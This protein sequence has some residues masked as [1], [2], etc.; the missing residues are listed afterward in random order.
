LSR[1]G[2]SYVSIISEWKKIVGLID[3]R[4][5]RLVFVLIFVYGLVFSSYT[6]FMYYAFKTY[7]WDLGV[8]SQ[9]LWTTINTGKPFHYTLETY[10]NPGQSFF[11]AHFSPILALVVPAYAVYQSPLTL[12]VLQSF[13]IGL[14][15]LPLYWI[16]RDKLNSK[17]WGLTF[18][19]AFLLQPALHGMNCF[20]FHLEAFIPLFFLFAFYYFDN[21][22]WFKGFVFSLLILSTIEFAPVLMLSLGLYFLVKVNLRQPKTSVKDRLRKMLIPIF[23]ILISILWFFL[24]L[25]IMYSLNPVKSIGL[26][27][28]WDNWGRSLS[29]VILNVIRNPIRALATMVN[30]LDKVYYFISILAP[31]VFL[32]FLAPLELILI[33]PWALAASLS[34]YSPYYEPY[35]QYFGFVAA[36]IF[37]AAVIGAQR[38][39]KDREAHQNHSGIEKKLMTMILLVSLIS[40]IVVSPI[41]IQALTTR[42]VE[43]DSHTSTLEQVL[44]LI[45]SNASVATENNIESHLA[46][47]ENVFILT[48]PMNMKVDYIIL[49]L[50]S[51]DILYGP[52]PALLSPIEALRGVLDSKEYGIVVYADGVMLLERGYVGQYSMFKPYQRSFTSEDLNTGSSQSRVVYDESSQSGNVIIHRPNDRLGVIWFGPYSW[53]F[54]GEYNVTFR[55]EEESQNPNLTL[56]ISAAYWN[57]TT[58]DWSTDTIRIK[59]LDGNDFTSP[60]KWQEFTINF[61]IDDLRRMEF[62]GFCWSDNTFVEL[63][64]VKVVQVEP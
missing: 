54:A 37:I 60:N 35:Y 62:R 23:L 46:E 20:P 47:R 9:V 5:D 55:M 64:N 61:R 45:P 49:D 26:P 2:R 48:W 31:V 32:V 56:D 50:T 36:Q 58:N 6:I 38:L 29:E 24:A 40:A 13:V 14:A 10:A 15:A 4:A 51:S 33:L 53:L 25:Y 16:A 34:Q 39:F 3:R 27:G 17:L 22:H 52:Y 8:F 30:P 11:G 28:N 42:R 12:L 57:L 44:A 59:T 43:I 18:A 7:A 1:L 41:G 63:D 19:A 21:G